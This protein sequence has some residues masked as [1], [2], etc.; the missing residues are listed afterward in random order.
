MVMGDTTVTLTVAVV[1]SLVDIAAT[2]H[3]VGYSPAVYN[4]ADV[5]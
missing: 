4:P 5:I 2:V 1:P 3:V